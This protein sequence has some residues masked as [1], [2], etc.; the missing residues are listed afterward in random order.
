MVRNLTAF[1]FIGI[2]FLTFSPG[3][4]ANIIFEGYYAIRSGDTAIGYAVQRFEFDEKKKLFTSTSLLQTNAQAGNSTEGFKAIAKENFEPVSYQYTFQS[5]DQAKTID[6]TFSG[7]QMTA[8][9]SD[10][11][12]ATK[13]QKEL[14][15]GTFLSSFLAYLML[16]QG[17]KVDTKYSYAAIAEEDGEIYKGEALIQGEQTYNGLEVFRIVNKF[18]NVTFTSFVT[19]RGEVLGTESAE[20]NIK[21]E[22]VANRHLATHGMTLPTRVLQ[23]LFGGT[24]EGKENPIAKKASEAAQPTP[25]ATQAP[26]ATPTPK[27]K[28]VPEAKPPDTKDNES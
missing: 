11:T 20:Q 12:T 25:K 28:P 9:L 8:T 10:G 5:G 15:E 2:I 17:Y 6:A 22:L 14:P 27:A 23:T 26:K 13:T 21:T 18:K 3:I 19:A 24:P 1:F 7:R 16:R 4:K